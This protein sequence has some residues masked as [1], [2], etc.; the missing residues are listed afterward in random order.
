MILS[1][2]QLTDEIEKVKE[3]FDLNTFTEQWM[4]ECERNNGSDAVESIDV[5]DHFLCND[6][7]VCTIFRSIKRKC[8]I[9]FGNGE[10]I[11]MLRHSD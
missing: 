6:S 11:Y 2:F 7:S 3:D 9:S 4:E 10:A 1:D 5:S 8:G